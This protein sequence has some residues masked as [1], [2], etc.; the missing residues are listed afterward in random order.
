MEIGLTEEASVDTGWRIRL[1]RRLHEVP[2]ADGLR[3]V[4]CEKRPVDREPIAS[5]L[6]VHGL[7]QNRHSFS[8]P[9]RSFEHYL[10]GRG[11]GTFNLELRGHGLSRA[12]GA[13]VP[14]SF[15]AYLDYDLPAAVDFVGER[16][17]GRP[18]FY[19]GHSLGGT[20]S[21][22]VGPRLQP[23]LA[24]IVSIAGP[25][26]LGEGNLPMRLLAR[27]GVA[28]DRLTRL[29]RTLPRTFYVD[30]IGLLARHGLFALDSRLTPGAIQFWHPGGVEREVA[31]ERIALGFDRTS[32]SVFWL[33]V[34]WA[35][36]GR[37]HGTRGG[38][39]LEERIA[40]LR[41]P[42]LFVVGDRD[43][44]V[45]SAAV[46]QAYDR[47]GSPDRTLAI[48]GDDRLDYHFGHLDLICGRWAPARVWPVIADWMLRRVPP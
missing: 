48:F 41:V 26:H 34:Q 2:T 28:L 1:R 16:N 36:S 24:G 23:K 42:I 12:N 46:Q 38:T 10:L 8:L 15:E 18:I 44:V 17:G 3:L 37:L 29:T 27:T 20:I 9:T 30:F 4:A 33:L 45:P 13:D 19:L 32:F 35:A 5:V 31:T 25:F 39:E 11:F 22:C 7:G 6:L 21:Y 14:E 47:A 43:G 40:E